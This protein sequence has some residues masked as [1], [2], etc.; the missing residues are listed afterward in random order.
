MKI[1]IQTPGFKAT[2]KLTGFVNNHVTK[3]AGFSDRILEGQVVL[4][5]DKSDRKDNK[6]CELR[7]VIPGNDLFSEKRGDKFEE[8]VTKCIEAIRH[9][10]GRRKESSDNGKRRG[11]ATSPEPEES[12]D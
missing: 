2:K 6:V 4:K 10:I 1:N 5:L 11:S 7:L 8:V 9:Q 3:L 12:F